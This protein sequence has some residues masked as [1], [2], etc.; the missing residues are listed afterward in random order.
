M[1]DTVVIFVYG[2]LK[3]GQRNHH[4]LAKQNF[5][6]EAQTIAQYRIYDLGP[7]PIIVHDPEK[8]LAVHGE[9][10]EVDETCLQKLDEFE[11]VPEIF[12]RQ[13]IIVA[14]YYGE[15]PQAYFRH[16]PPPANTLSGDCWPLPD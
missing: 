1:S 11:E 12:Y 15:P 5:L 16:E 7:H 4:Y 6:G 3:R 2:T 13:D 14:N 10:W 9:L 8:G